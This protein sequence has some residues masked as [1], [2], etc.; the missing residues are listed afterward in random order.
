MARPT[1][2]KDGLRIDWQPVLERAAEVAGGA[3]MT[4]RQCFYIVVSEL[5]ALLDGGVR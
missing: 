3:P 4:S 1:S 5:L 2:G